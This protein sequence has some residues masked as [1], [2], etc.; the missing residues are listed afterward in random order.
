MKKLLIAL[1]GIVI[2]GTAIGAGITQ[3]FA[4]DG[5]E[6]GLG[7]SGD[8]KTLTVD[9]G[10]GVNNPKMTI[11]ATDKDFDFSKS[12]TVS[13]NSLAIGDGA[14]SNKSLVF[15]EGSVNKP[16]I[17]WNDSSSELE[18]SNDGSVYEALGS[19]S[20]KSDA[21]GSVQLLDNTDAELSTSNWTASGGAFTRTTTNPINGAG[22]FSWDASAASQTLR[23]DAVTIPERLQGAQCFARMYYRT[24]A[25]DYE[26]EVVD[27]SNAL[28][29]DQTQYLTLPDTPNSGADTKVAEISFICP[30]SG[31]LKV[32]LQSA[33]D[34][35]EIVF[36]DVVLGQSSDFQ[37][38]F[39]MFPPADPAKGNPRFK[40]GAALV[41]T[42]GSG[43]VTW[44]SGEFISS[45]T[46]NGLGD[47]TVNFET[48]MFDEVP[49][50]TC[51]SNRSG[52]V[53]DVSDQITTTTDDLIRIRNIDMAGTI[54]EDA[55]LNLHCIGRAVQ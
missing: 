20:G 26:F 44:Q 43:S 55:T 37:D 16:E 8:D 1:A 6:F 3:K 38:H 51:N 39:A 40:I 42:S 53:C 45:V 23:S 48:V 7:S 21:F 17:R 22:S 28:I 46:R 35:A 15:D 41:D 30:A 4:T 10:D 54:T 47:V 36:D 27:G 2:V 34:A 24:S 11:D 50:C 25:T 33:S 32:E 18:F 29:A 19:G 13:G 49:V 14:A 31:S 52:R 12:V 9:V 5:V